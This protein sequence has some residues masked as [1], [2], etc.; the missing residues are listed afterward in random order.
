MKPLSYRTQKSVAPYRLWIAEGGRR[1]LMHGQ[2]TSGHNN[3]VPVKSVMEAKRIAEHWRASGVK[4]P[5]TFPDYD[6]N[7]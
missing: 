5:Y 3:G 6:A 7:A 4:P 1:Y 2:K